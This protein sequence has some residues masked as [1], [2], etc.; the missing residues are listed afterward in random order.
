MKIQYAKINIRLS[1]LALIGHVNAII[2]EYETAG[3]SLTLRQVYYQLVS[4]DLIDNSEKSYKHV[5]SLA[6]NGRLAG[7]IDWQAIEDR[8]RT[9]RRLPHWDAPAEIVES[10]ASQ[11]RCDLWEGQGRYCEVWVEK[12]ALIGIVE[13]SAQR[14]DCPCFS[15]RGYTS[16]SEMWGAAMRFVDKTNNG[17]ECVLIHL[18][19]HD[20]SGIDMTRD[21]K[22]RLAM[23]GASV[24]VK[25]IA[26]NMQQIE[27]YS[28]PPNPAKETDTRAA[29]YIAKYGNSS[30]ELDAL[31]PRALDA[32]I[33]AAI[34]SNL[35]QKKYSR[36]IKKQEAERKSIAALLPLINKDNI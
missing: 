36:A 2:S 30:W 7:L 1:G 14:L 32:L 4:R 24:D 22:E 17:R 5:G 23:F 20:P 16:Q 13:Q 31:E 12:D 26:L 10:A 33:T 35:D 15:C 29:G 28:P 3:Y 8:T 9:L 18:G 25:R 19:D 27:E 34:K 21:I 11:Y 6:S